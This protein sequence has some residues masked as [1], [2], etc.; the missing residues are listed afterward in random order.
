MNRKSTAKVIVQFLQGAVKPLS[1]GDTERA[2]LSGSSSSTK[3]QVIL[4]SDFTAAFNAGCRI[5]E[6]RHGAR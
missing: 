2:I 4:R 5:I 1:R 3:M 6:D